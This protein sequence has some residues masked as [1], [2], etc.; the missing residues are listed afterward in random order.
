MDELMEAMSRPP[1]VSFATPIDETVHFTP[2]PLVTEFIE[3]D[4]ENDN[5]P[6]IN[7]YILEPLVTPPPVNPYG[8]DQEYIPLP[9]PPTPMTMVRDL[10]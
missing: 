8:F 2:S 9:S 3:E 4:K 10:Q 1:A 5:P 6:D 7:D